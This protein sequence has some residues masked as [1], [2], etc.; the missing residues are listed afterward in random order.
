MIALRKVKMAAAVCGLGL[1]LSVTGAVTPAFAEVVD[2]QSGT[3]RVTVQGDESKMRFEVPTVIPFAADADGMLTGPDPSTI[4]IKKLSAFP[5]HLQSV[6]VTSSEDWN[7]YEDEDQVTA[8]STTNNIA[9]VVGPQGH[10]INAGE[11]TGENGV[12]VGRDA[13]FDLSYMG[14][15]EEHSSIDLV[16]GGVIG[17][18]TDGNLG[19]GATV[20][21]ITWTFAPGGIPA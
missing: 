11:A 21:T 15:T 4:Q 18:V 12:G 13:V 9:F 7:I 5:I 8:A 6:K 2:G 16:T 10:L 1:A 20:A 19:A 3:T 14:D 17:K